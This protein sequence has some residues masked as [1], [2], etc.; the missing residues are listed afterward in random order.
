[1]YADGSHRQ[2]HRLASES[3]R[4]DVSQQFPEIAAKMYDMTRGYYET[5]KYMLYHNKP[6][7][8]DRQ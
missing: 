3:P 6:L 2:L 5:A 1:M 7:P 8:E 4:D